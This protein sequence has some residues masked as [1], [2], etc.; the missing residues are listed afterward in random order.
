[1]LNP[2][3]SAP[4]ARAALMAGHRWVTEGALPPPNAVLAAA[5][6]GEIDPVY[7]SETG[8]A[9]NA[10]GN[11]IGG[12]QL[13]EV[14]VGQARYQAWTDFPALPLPGGIFAPLLGLF[15]D[16]GCEPA[17]GS[18]GDEPRFRNHGAYVNAYAR[19][20]AE[21][22]RQGYLLPDEAERMVDAA[23]DSD[24]GKPKSCP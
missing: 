10:D 6:P 23:G 2:L 19:Q 9:R 22:V 7:G 1:M 5:A 14:A 24:I 20:A 8:I 18:D 17:A 13:P 21:L 15:E 4:V 16:L 11:A 12:V 3:D